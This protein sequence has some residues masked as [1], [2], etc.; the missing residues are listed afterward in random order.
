M[1][2]RS[3][4]HA[5]LCRVFSQQYALRWAAMQRFAAQGMGGMAGMAT[6]G[7]MGGMGPMTNMAAQSGYGMMAGAVGGAASTGADGKN[8]FWKTRICNK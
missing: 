3:R 7:N 1:I 8:L 6:M 2:Q 4:D 5:L